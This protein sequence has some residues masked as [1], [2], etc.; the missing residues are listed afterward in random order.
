MAKEGGSRYAEIL[1]SA[2]WILVFL[3]VLV[4]IYWSLLYTRTCENQ[5]CFNT[6][7]LECKKAEWIN[8]A[9]EAT[10]LY[11]IKGIS[12]KTCEVEVKLLVIKS[13]KMDMKEA[14][15]KMM[16]CKIPE[17]VVTNPSQNLEYCSGLLKEEF[18]ELI[19]KR[20][21]SYILENLGEISE[22]LTKPIQ[23]SS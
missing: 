12:E 6:Y 8:D 13:G 21:H 14:E 15:G 3:I 20:M 4:V 17:G 11:T 23:N 2:I 19:I 22:E 9:E 1:K 7:L 10:W 16:N 18:Q 5:E